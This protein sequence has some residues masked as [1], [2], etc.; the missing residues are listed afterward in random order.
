M[1]ATTYFLLIEKFSYMN[2][3]TWI[4]IDKSGENSYPKNFANRTLKDR[5]TQTSLRA[6]SVNPLP[7]WIRGD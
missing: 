2:T 1:R 3:Q 6:C 7:K 4:L 5:K